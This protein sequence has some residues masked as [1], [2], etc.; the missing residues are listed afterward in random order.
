M[1]FLGLRKPGQKDSVNDYND[2]LVPLATSKR[3]ATVEA[4][5]A[6]RRSAEGRGSTTDTSTFGPS[7]VEENGEGEKGGKVS[8]PYTV[9]G[10]RAE[11]M[12]DVDAGGHD[13]AYDCEFCSGW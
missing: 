6:R 3:H 10:L 9:E 4:E 11:C 8:S 5:Y 7:K 1:G 13:T 12:Q 2:V